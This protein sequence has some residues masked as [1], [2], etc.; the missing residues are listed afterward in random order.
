MRQL[1]GKC[2]IYIQVIA[3]YVEFSVEHKYQMWENTG[4][5]R[6]GN[7]FIFDADTDMLFFRPCNYKMRILSSKICK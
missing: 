2:R 7:Y 3:V 1:F 6:K 4:L 5:N